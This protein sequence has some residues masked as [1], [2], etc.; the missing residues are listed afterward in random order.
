MSEKQQA[1]FDAMNPHWMIFCTV[2]FSAVIICLVSYGIVLIGKLL[3]DVI[4]DFSKYRTHLKEQ[5][6]KNNQNN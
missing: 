4:Y 1:I 5:K 2:M 6:I 3:A